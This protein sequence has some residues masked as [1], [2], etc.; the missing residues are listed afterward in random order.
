MNEAAGW[1]RAAVEVV[2]VF[3]RPTPGYRMYRLPGIGKWG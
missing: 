3:E 2:G 1:G